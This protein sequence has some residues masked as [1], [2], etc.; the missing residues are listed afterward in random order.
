M[1]ITT[2][3]A[4]MS[5][6]TFS[7]PQDIERPGFELVWADEFRGDENDPPNPDHWTYDLGAGGWGN[8][9]LQYYTDRT[10]NVDLN[11][12]GFLR[13]QA[14]RETFEGA[15]FTSARIKSEAL[16]EIQYG[17]IDIRARAPQERGVWPALWM[18]GNDIS[19]V[20]WPGCG[21]IDIMEIFGQRSIGVAVHGPGYS[22][23][24]AIGFPYEPA[25]N[26]ADEIHTYSLVW[27]PEHLAW[28]IDDE[29][30][31]SINPS[32]LPE[33]TPWVFDHPFFFIVNVA[34]GGNTVE[35]P[36]GSTP[37]V[38]R[39]FVD[40]I[41]VYERVPALRDPAATEEE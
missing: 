23:G 25:E 16:Q 11:G 15:P 7:L 40:Y 5:A 14:R 1:R 36:D 33:F 13:I 31:A 34:V 18:L 26:F 6:C 22:G 17:R 12:D 2:L 20:G 27:D 19:E 8:N 4:L 41:R 21:E 29:L 3:T 30:V 9:E 28:L 35:T 10:E 32:D 37:D 24:D 39:L 38:N